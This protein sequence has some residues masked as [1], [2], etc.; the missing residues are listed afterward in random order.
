VPISGEQVQQ[1]VSLIAHDLHTILGWDLS[2]A[3]AEALREA[4]L[5][6]AWDFGGVRPR[7]HLRA[8]RRRAGAAVVARHHQHTTWPRC[9]RH[10]RHPLWL[11]DPHNRSVWRCTQDAVDIAPLGSLA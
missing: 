3:E 6:A 4:Q 7:R 10:P 11:D 1:A 9:P 5:V 2:R 8:G